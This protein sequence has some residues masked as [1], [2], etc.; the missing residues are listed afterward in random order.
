M[1]VEFTNEKTL[2]VI[3]PANLKVLGEVK[4]TDPLTIPAIV[5]EASLSVHLWNERGLNY[6]LNKIKRFKKLLLE[7]QKEIAGL[8][9]QESGKPVMESLAGEIFGVL[10][11]CDWLKKNTAKLL[12][13]QKVS[14]NQLM[15]FGKR[16]YNIFEPIGVIAIISP[17][18]FPFSISVNSMLMALACG[19]TV[20][21]KPSPKTPLIGQ[22][23]KKLFD[24]AGFPSGV[25]NV[26]QGDKDVASHL[27]LADVARVVFTG[28]VEGGKA[29]MS[30]AAQK[31]HPV[32]LELGGKHPAIVLADADVEK[33]AQTIVWSSF[34]N[35]GQACAAIERLYVERPIADKLS[36]RI[37]ELTSQ[38]Q[39]GDSLDAETDIGPLIDAD[40]LRRVKA[41]VEQAVSC[42]AKIIAG[43]KER[44]DLGGYFFEP[45]VLVD[46]TDQMDVIRQEIFG[47][48]LPIMVVEDESEAVRRAN[49][50]N[51]ALG[52]SIW[53]SNTKHGEE[54]ARRIQSGMV[55]INDALYSHIAPDAPWGGM[56]DSGF[57][58][59]HSALSLRELVNVKHIGV[60][61]QGKRN[62]NFPYSGNSLVLI[63]TALQACHAESV[64]S[65]VSAFIRLPFALLNARK[66]KFFRRPK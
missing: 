39:L 2:R 58:R 13:P 55:W 47:P 22:A 10:E 18:N 30:L 33:I 42:G 46:V 25:V 26:V 63:R 23:I 5:K 56:K 17:W 66:D 14:L 3:N 28:G 60:D 62:W 21:L 41:Q 24:Q 40:Q 12:Q 50:S 34:T 36:K 43:G 6:R 37:A 31:L 19:N 11:T 32:T 53:T 35:A 57:G 20:V 48:I 4:L 15:F 49:N 27:V 9:S 52:A 1:A 64:I 8:L 59:S 44:P 45:T 65:R 38:L 16:S 54:L 61:K 7:N 29:I 51:L